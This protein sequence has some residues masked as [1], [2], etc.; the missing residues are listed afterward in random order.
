VIEKERVPMPTS[1]NG[2][3]L[4]KF[5]RDIPDFPKPGILFRDI[6]PL[7]Q[8]PR[9]FRAA[10][11]NLADRY[12]GKRVDKVLCVESRGFLFGAPLAV[13]LGA[14]LVIARKPGKLPWKTKSVRYALE[15]GTDVI[16]M[17]EDSIL[18]GERV[19]IVDDLLATGGTAS[20]GVQLVTDHKGKV[21]ECAFVIELEALGGRKRL[22]P[23]K[24]FSVLRY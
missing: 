15:Y 22:A 5:I 14:G 19:L 4:K 9:A 16:E 24:V 17:H 7:L 2:L 11:R 18:A 1:S 12:K 20:A 3:D 13:K 6:T 10:I 21:V 23:A 8:N